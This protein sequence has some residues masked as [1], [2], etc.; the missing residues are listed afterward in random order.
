TR[1][2]NSSGLGL[3]SA[4]GVTVVRLI[5]RRGAGTHACRVPTPG[6]A[7][8]TPATRVET[9][10]DTAGTSACATRLHYFLTWAAASSARL[11][12]RTLTRGSPRTPNWRSSVLAA[13][14]LRR[15]S[16]G[17]AR[18]GGAGAT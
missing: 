11:S 3:R 5:L 13:T 15:G 6:D 8:V 7:L 4:R 16:A 18:A 2:S 1:R 14:N 17:V 10:L 9:S 12:F